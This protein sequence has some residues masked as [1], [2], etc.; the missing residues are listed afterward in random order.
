MHQQEHTKKLPK[1]N[2]KEYAYLIAGILIVGV[3]GFGFG[4]YSGRTHTPYID[5]VT[6]VDHKEPEVATTADFDAFWKAWTIINEKALNAPKLTDQDRVWGAISGLVGSLND[7]YSVFFKP[8]ENKQF[9]EQISGEFSGIGAEIGMKDNLLT[10]IAPL[11]GSPAEAAGIKSGDKILKIN[12]KPTSNLT[13]D[14]AIKL[15]RGEKGTTVNLNIYHAGDKLSHDVV[16]TRNTIELPTIDGTLRPDG[17]YVLSLY[18]FNANSADLFKQKIEEFKATGSN[19]LILDLRGNPGGYLEAALD[20][21]SWFLPQ[22]TPVVI[23]D[24]GTKSDKKIY[25][26]VG[27]QIFDSKLKMA[28]LVDGGSASASEILSGALSEQHV[29]TL[30]GEQ[31]FGKGSVQELIPLTSDT[32]LKITVAKWLTPNGVSISEK[33]LTPQVVV[34]PSTDTSKSAPDTQLDAAVQYL[35]K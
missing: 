34:P 16:V 26:S 33:G 25:R 5:Q 11:K 22:G 13:V 6:G 24:F 28:I 17:V 21:A 12:N 10:V 32:S 35:N 3:I 4:F 2:K 9:N 1:L 23:E 15:I 18:T 19:K 7:P 8:E 14:D 27:H 31:T 30:I 29:A 20:M